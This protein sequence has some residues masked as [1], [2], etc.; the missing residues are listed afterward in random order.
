MRYQTP[1]SHL[2]EFV[3]HSYD[4]RPNWTLALSHITIMNWMTQILLPFNQH[5]NK[6][7]KTKH[8]LLKIYSWIK[9]I[10]WL[11]GRKGTTYSRHIGVLYKLSCWCTNQ[12]AWNKS[13]W[14]FVLVSVPCAHVCVLATAF[15]CLVSCQYFHFS[16]AHGVIIIGLIQI[17]LIGIHE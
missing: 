6:I 1:A 10:S 12:T 8:K 7:W 3:N 17:S 15:S 14:H 4:C 5:C 16:C 9:T 2:S 11:F 13:H